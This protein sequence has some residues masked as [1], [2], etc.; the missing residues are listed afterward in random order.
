MTTQTMNFGGY[1]APST[2]DWFGIS[3]GVLFFRGCSLNC[4][5]CQNTALLEGEKRISLYTVRKLIGESEFVISGVVF[6]G[7]EPLEQAGPLN[8]LLEWCQRR[9]LKTYL[10]T[11]GNCPDSLLKVIGKLNG[12]RLDFKPREQFDCEETYDEYKKRFNASLETIKASGIDYLISSVAVEQNY[13]LKDI[14]TTLDKDLK[15][16]L[17]VQGNEC[18]PKTVRQLKEEFPGCYLFSR[19]EGLKPN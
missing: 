4:K 16:V 9:G 1:T 7:G 10:H 2:I 15:K 8:Q 18:D 12:V 5:S 19:E 3:A 13:S 6:S 11:S 14:Y 17:I